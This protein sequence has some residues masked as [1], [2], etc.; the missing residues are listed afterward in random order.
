[1]RAGHR[2]Q[3]DPAAFSSLPPEHGLLA[4]VGTV[5][6][7]QSSSVCV[8]WDG[9]APTSGGSIYH[10]NQLILAPQDEE[11]APPREPRGRRP[12]PRPFRLVRD[13]DVS[14]VSGTGIV[15]EGVEFIDGTVALRWMSEH[16]TSVVFHD[17]GI[18][19][20]RAIHGH[21]GRTRIE[22]IP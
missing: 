11:P 22:F 14:G 7:V 19:S 20:V 9:E 18:D 2:V 17:R 5:I 21:D 6:G 10:E 3:R 12:G 15:A 16:P 13:E 4:E 1:M 8:R